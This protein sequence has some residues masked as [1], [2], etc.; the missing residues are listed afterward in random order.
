MP[1]PNFYEVTPLED[2]CSICHRTPRVTV[3]ARGRSGRPWKL[4]FNDDC[5]TM[6]EMREKKA[7]RLAAQEAKKKAD[8]AAGKSKGK[9]GGKK[10]TAAKGGSGKKSGAGTSRSKTVAASKSGP[11]DPGT[12]RVKRAGGRSRGGGSRG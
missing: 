10:K 3:K 1:Q 6:V 7:E 9:S 4:C 5:P 11:P 2:N 8:G 12:R